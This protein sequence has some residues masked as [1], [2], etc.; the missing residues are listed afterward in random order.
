MVDCGIR[1]IWADNFGAWDSFGRPPLRTAFG[2]WSVA[3]F[4]E[5]LARRFSL[6]QLRSMGVENVATFDVRTYLRRVLR[7]RLG[8]NDNNLADPKWSDP[9]WLDDPIWRQYRIYKCEVGRQAL[10]AFYQAFHQAARERGITDF[11]IQGNDIP[12]WCFDWP[13]PE[14]LDMVSTEFSPSWNLLSGPRGIGLPPGGRIGP[15][16]KMA[17]THARSRFV[18]VWYYIPDVPEWYKRYRGNAAVGRVLSYEMLAHHAMIHMAPGNQRIAGTRESHREVTNFIHAA[19]AAWGD[20]RPVAQIG[21]LYSPSSRLVYL[22]PGEL[23]LFNAQP[24]VFDLLGWG[25]ALCELHVQYTVIPEWDLSEEALRDFK[26]LLLPS[27]EVLSPEAVQKVLLP[28]VRSGGRLILSGP[29]GGRYD[30]ARSHAPVDN[31]ARMLPELCSLAKVD[32]QAPRPQSHEASVGQGKV[33][34]LP[35]L[36]FEY[37][38]Q[39][40]GERHLSPIESAIRNYLADF[41]LVQGDLARELEV[42]LFRSP[43]NGTLFVDIA[44]LDLN[45]DTD[46]EPKPHEAIVTLLGLPG[47]S[48]LSSAEAI[49]PKDAPATVPMKNDAH[50]VTI[51]PIPVSNYVSIVLR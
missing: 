5:Y 31:A 15:L 16:I 20:R 17:R 19:K 11:C 1:G 23:V 43:T 40:P 4:R 2:E 37:Y 46:S 35:P 12:I 22:A 21:L 45:P 24:H 33:I 14:Y 28:W 36:G 25:T 42:S 44:N 26:A 41:G 18:H 32:P 38:Q 49:A 47:V 3:G 50:T 30:A 7:D 39:T 34:L 27:V 9:Y 48:R 6:R 29:C 13:R 10:Q 51:G 8:G